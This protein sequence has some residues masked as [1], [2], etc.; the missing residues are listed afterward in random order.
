[1]KRNESFNTHKQ[2]H[3]NILFSFQNKLKIKPSEQ[4]LKFSTVFTLSKIKS[5]KKR[6]SRAAIPKQGYFGDMQVMNV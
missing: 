1:M 6:D 3:Y 4:P 2:N 5:K